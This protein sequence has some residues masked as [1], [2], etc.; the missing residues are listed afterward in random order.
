MTS[1]QDAGISKTP[2]RGAVASMFGLAAEE[3]RQGSSRHV[4]ALPRQIAMYLAKQ[5]TD[6]SLHEIGRH[7]GGRHNTTVMHSIAKI[8]ATE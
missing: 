1:N 2:T 4:V 6:A 3:L 8:P 7:F 5:M